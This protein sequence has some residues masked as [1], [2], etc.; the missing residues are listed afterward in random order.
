MFRNTL[1]IVFGL[2]ITACSGF[3]P[4][5]LVVEGLVIDTPS[6]HTPSI[7]VNPSRVSIVAES[8]DTTSTSVVKAPR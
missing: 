1:R 8:T 5:E 4:T 7:Q 3:T 6:A 2:Y